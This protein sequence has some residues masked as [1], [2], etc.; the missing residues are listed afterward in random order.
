[1]NAERPEIR[2]NRAT[3][4]WTATRP[5]YGFSGGLEAKTDFA[6]RSDALDW[7]YRRR[8]PGSVSVITELAHA[9]TDGVGP[10][11]TWTPLFYPPY[12]IPMT[13][14]ET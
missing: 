11:P 6:S 9:D 13:A 8:N 14:K 5:R 4:K 2:K 10:V 12:P 3:G 7:L 1:V